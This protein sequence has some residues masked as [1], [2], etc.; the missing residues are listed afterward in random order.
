MENSYYYFGDKEKSY[1]GIEDL[2]RPFVLNCAGYLARTKKLRSDPRVRP[3]WFLRV[4]DAG[5][6]IINDTVTI[7]PRQFILLPPHTPFFAAAPK[8]PA[9][10]YWIHITGDQ[11]EPLLR[12]MGIAP[13]QVYE[14]TQSAMASVKQSFTNLFREATLCQAG[15][16]EMCA[17]I[18]QSILIKLCRGHLDL[19][20]ND[21]AAQ[22]RKRLS[23]SVQEMH[24]RY[25]S[26]LNIT[27]LAQ[28][29]NLS[30]SRYREIF[31]LA[32]GVSPREYLMKLRISYG[33]ELLATTELS[34]TE[35][36]SACGFEDVMYFSRLFHKK[37]GTS[38]GSYRKKLW[39][40][41]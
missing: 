6:Q 39:G 41:Q 35:V 15:Y 12:S 1:A 9:A 37:V 14:I 17:S 8:G 24:F 4:M 18:A 40:T 7:L 29:E 33:Q 11:V 26:G 31:R 2:N 13:G 20:Q 34:V 25:T 28:L 22:Y 19:V 5:M 36:A 10:F 32:F 23:A 21:M 16:E 27:E 3:D 38:P 30:P